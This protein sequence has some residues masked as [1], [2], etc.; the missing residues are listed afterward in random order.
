MERIAT[1]LVNEETKRK[2]G[3]K[4]VILIPIPTKPMWLK[5]KMKTWL[6]DF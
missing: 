4:E 2:M 5:S 6:Y 3:K 1:K